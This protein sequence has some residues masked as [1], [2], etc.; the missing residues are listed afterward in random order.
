MAFRTDFKSH[1]LLCSAVNSYKDS[2][3]NKREGHLQHKVLGGGGATEDRSALEE[4]RTT[5]LYEL[6]GKEVWK[7]ELTDVC[8]AVVGEEG[9]LEGVYFL[10]N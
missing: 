1:L 10:T 6:S 2:G 9:K 7:G 8:E 4:G 3:Q 5:A